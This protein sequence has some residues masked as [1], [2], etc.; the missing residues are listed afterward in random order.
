[1]PAYTNVREAEASR[2]T[3]LEVQALEIQA[4][5]KRKKTS[6]TIKDLVNYCNQNLKSDLLLYPDKDNP[7][8]PKRM[9]T[10]L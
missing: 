9:C 5:M 7:F 2:R 6:E 1:M 3:R 10:I 8:K 4:R